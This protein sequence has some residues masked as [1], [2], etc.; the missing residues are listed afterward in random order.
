MKYEKKTNAYVLHTE[1]NNIHQAQFLVSQSTL[2]YAYNY[3]LF[4]LNSLTCMHAIFPMGRYLHIL[5]LRK[6]G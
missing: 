1:Q 4:G 5:I 3:Y 2:T 6:L